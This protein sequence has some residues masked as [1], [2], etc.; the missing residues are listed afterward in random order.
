[1]LL[2]CVAT[3][4]EGALLKESG[5]VEPLV[6]GI[7]PVNAAAA[8]T[9]AIA[10]ERPSRILVCGVCGAYPGSGLAVLDVTCA[11][12]ETYGDQSRIQILSSWRESRDSL[13]ETFE[14]PC[15]WHPW[16]NR[17]LTMWT[18]PTVNWGG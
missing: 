8:L 7:G 17:R 13:G 1:M 11:A 12:S 5:H 15:V 9:A 16:A 4:L 3:D 6:T 2:V 14:Y 10:H 18:G